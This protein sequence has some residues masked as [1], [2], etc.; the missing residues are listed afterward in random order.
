MHSMSF[1]FGVTETIL[2]DKWQTT[3]W[4]EVLGSA[5]GIILLGAVYEALK[6][7]RDYL[8]KITSNNCQHR[9]L[10]KKKG[11]LSIVHAIQT[12]LHAIQ[13]ILGYFLMF[14]FMTYNVYLCIAVVLGMSFGYFLFAWQKSR[15]DNNE[16]CS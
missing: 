11:I 2:F 13:A 14:I 6:S 7:Y 16:C 3:N 15:S 12:I 5:I 8:Y 1:H 4:Q 10:S 9:V